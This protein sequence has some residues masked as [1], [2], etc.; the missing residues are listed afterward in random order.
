MQ[1]EIP[2]VSIDSIYCTPLF[3][4]IPT[5]VLH[6]TTAAYWKYS[7]PIHIY[8]PISA[9]TSAHQT[10]HPLLVTLLLLADEGP[11]AAAVAPSSS[12]SGVYRDPK[13]GF[14]LAVPSGW[15]Q[16]E[17]Q[18]EGNTSFTGGLGFRILRLRV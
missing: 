17:G 10:A 6:I 3:N 15:A 8:G 9:L 5:S 18:L 1:L 14:S 12:S 2:F 16:A 4:N 7:G 11:A 13:E